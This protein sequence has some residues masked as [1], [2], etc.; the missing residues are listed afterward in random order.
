M[1]MGTMGVFSHSAQS[2]FYGSSGRMD[3][4]QC[5]LLEEDLN[6]R[7]VLLHPADATQAFCRGSKARNLVLVR[8]SGSLS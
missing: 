2:A 5:H 8:C 4:A 3:G 1:E 7:Y 6:H